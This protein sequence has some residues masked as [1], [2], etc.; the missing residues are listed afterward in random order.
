LPTWRLY[1][2]HW[3]SLNATNL[4]HGTD[5]FTSPP[6]EGVMRIFSSIKIR[7]FEPANLGAKDQHAI[8]RPPKPLYNV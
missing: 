2:R 4:L 7:W 8:P 5:D 3:G 6:K 1:L